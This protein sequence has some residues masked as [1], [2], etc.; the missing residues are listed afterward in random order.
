MQMYNP[1]RLKSGN[2]SIATAAGKSSGRWNTGR[3]TIATCG[4]WAIRNANRRRRWP[5]SGAQFN[6][7]QARARISQWTPPAKRATRRPTGSVGS[8]VSCFDV[9]V[10]LRGEHL[11]TDA[12]AVLA[13]IRDKP[14][15]AGN[16][17]SRW[18]VIAE[19]AN[20]WTGGRPHQTV[21]T[22]LA[23]LPGGA[24]VCEVPLRCAT[25]RQPRPLI[26]R[27]CWSPFAG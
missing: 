23:P 3:C 11:N 17:H 5:P 18:H 8:S 12:M 26:G 21:W 15:R 20:I 25:N 4:R 24:F 16:V 19:R 9:V 2:G 1:T 7:R 14:V 27:A 6:P 13:V 10:P 22:N